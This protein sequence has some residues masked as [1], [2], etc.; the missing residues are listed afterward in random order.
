MYLKLSHRDMDFY[1]PSNRCTAILNHFKDKQ[2]LEIR[3]PQR[4]QCAILTLTE[5]KTYIVWMCLFYK[6][7]KLQ[8]TSVQSPAL[9]S[10]A[11][12]CAYLKEEIGMRYNAA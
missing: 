4:W 9:N 10:I 8:D 5:D 6:C 7:G 11:S 3:L 1:K 2:C 12:L